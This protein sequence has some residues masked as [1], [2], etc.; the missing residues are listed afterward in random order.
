MPLVATYGFVC[1]KWAS[2]QDNLPCFWCENETYRTLNISVCLHP[3]AAS[4]SHLVLYTY[5]CNMQRV[6]LFVRFFCV[7][8]LFFMIMWRSRLVLIFSDKTKETFPCLGWTILSWCGSVLFLLY[9][10]ARLFSESRRNPFES[11]IVIQ[12]CAEKSLNI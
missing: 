4:L 1:Q 2:A 9:V 7:N 3:S 10:D 6:F 12:C 8:V 5:C 11:M